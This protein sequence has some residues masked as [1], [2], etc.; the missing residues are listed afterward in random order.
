MP[1][2]KVFSGSGYHVTSRNT[3]VTRIRTTG[4]LA[5][6][7]Y[8]G[9]NRAHGREIGRIIVDELAPL[10]IGQDQP[11]RAVQRVPAFAGTTRRRQPSNSVY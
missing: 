2:K 11:T 3:I 7:V 5:S 6:E 9:D 4:G 1:L 10:L 8:N